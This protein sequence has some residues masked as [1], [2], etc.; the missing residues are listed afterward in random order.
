M[1]FRNRILLAIWGVVV[2]LLLITF[3]F[4][5]YWMRSQVESHF[6]DALRSN[7]SIVRE[8]SSLRAEQDIKSC[9]IIAESPRLKAVAD[10]GDRNAARNTALQLSLD[11]NNSISSDLFILTNAKGEPLSRLIAGNESSIEIDQFESIRRARKM[12]ESGD[13]WEINGT[14]YRVA[15]VPMKVGTDPVGTLTIGFRL[16]DQ[17]VASV[18]SMTNTDVVLVVD[19]T[20]I[21]ETTGALERTELAQWLRRSGRPYQSSQNVDVFTIDAS[22]DKYVSAFCRLNS[23]TT[24]PAIGYLLMKPVE[25]EVE[26][27]M[28]PI[29]GAL[30]ILSIIVLFVSAVIGFIISGGITRP[31]ASLVQGTTEISKG[32]YDYR[33]DVRSGGELKFLAQRFEEMSSSLKEK[34]SQLAERNAELESILHRLGDTEQLLQTILDTS[35]AI[36]YVKDIQGK[37]LLINRRFEV[38][39]NLKREEVIGKTDHELFPRE[40]ADGLRK[41]DWK[42]LEKGGPFEWEESRPQGDGHHSFIV[43]KFPLFDSSHVAY[44]VCAFMTDITDRKRLEEGLRQAQKLE[45]IGTLA[46]GIAHDF[47]NILGIILAYN[48]SIGRAK[49]DPDRFIESVETINQAVDRGT[50]LVRQMLTFARQTDVILQALNVNVVVSEVVKMLTATFPKT[51]EFVKT[52]DPDIPLVTADLTQVHQVLLNL[53]VNARD[54]MP[55]GGTITISTKMTP[56]PAVKKKFPAAIRDS[57]VYISIADTGTG[58]NEATRKRI[59]EPFFTTKELG[60]GTGLGLSVVYGVIQSHEG[61]IDVESQVG[62]GTIFHIYLP[63]ALRSTQPEKKTENVEAAIVGGTET[64]LL[65]EDEEALLA[66]VRKTLEAKGY[67]VLT[68]QDGLEALDFYRRHADQIAVVVSDMGL[69]KLGGWEAAK[70]MKELNGDAKIILASGFL[71]PGRKE[72]L[73]RDGMNHFI[74]KPYN[75]NEVLAKIREVIDHT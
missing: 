57:Y 25:R 56:A 55:E 66:L 44:A 3:L 53:C 28:A 5:N 11:L 7:Y 70:K 16:R 39:Y 74:Q 15:S 13:L 72:K 12:E 71:E 49:D 36:I 45:S 24:S 26:A 65:V 41:S 1:K 69:P 68:A 48:G 60:K 4:L 47:N 37:Y 20:V 30:L 17:D 32:N 22:I 75:P 19:T 27:S 40:T 6:A 34:V 10:L 46:G 42:A 8:I 73:M 23:G 14:V 18:K 51:I 61:F 35:T 43:N 38:L 62:K 31:I 9:K 67:R 2:G 59:F 63:A 50:A 64:I 33:I 29:R 21:D 52:L 58:I 54:A